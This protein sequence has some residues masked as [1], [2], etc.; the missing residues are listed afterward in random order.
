MN[1]KALI[2]GL[3]LHLPA[4][5]GWFSNEEMIQRA[6]EDGRQ[7]TS[8]VAILQGTEKHTEFNGSGTLIQ[9]E[10]QT[11]LATATHIFPDALFKKGTPAGSRFTRY[12]IEDTCNL[13]RSSDLKNGRAWLPENTFSLTTFYKSNS[14]DFTFIP[15]GQKLEGATHVIKEE[16]Y[17]E[18]LSFLEADNKMRASP[19][20]F[21]GI[22][23][24]YAGYGPAVV[25]HGKYEKKNITSVQ[26]A[27]YDVCKD[28]GAYWGRRYMGRLKVSQFFSCRKASFLEF[29]TLYGWTS[30]DK[31]NV[32]N[33][34]SALPGDS[35]GGF[36]MGVPGNE[37]AQLIGNVAFIYDAHFSVKDRI[38]GTGIQ[39]FH[40][41]I[42]GS[43]EGE[44]WWAEFQ[45]VLE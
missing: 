21:A 44:T 29:D 13:T 23:G 41:Q 20:P 11:I 36:F 37:D 45:R 22:D 4:L 18:A 34:S 28:A 42:K 27:Q 32:H 14:G 35:G 43:K 8:T 2:A 17:L 40:G 7:Q 9:G 39:P 15:L 24:F 25:L 26:L 5:S 33:F 10:E 16:G 19:H 31:E 6:E 1:K 30:F 3:C 12:Q 38:V